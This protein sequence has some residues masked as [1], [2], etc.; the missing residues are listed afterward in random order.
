M[1]KYFEDY[2]L[3]NHQANTMVIESICQV[4]NKEDQLLDL[5]SHLLNAHLI[6]LNRISTVNQ[7]IPTPWQRL[8]KTEFSPFN[9][10]LLEQTL[11]YLH[12]ATLGGD[13][14]QTIAYQTSTGAKFS[15]TVQQIYFHILAHSAYHRGQIA[16]LLRNKGIDPPLSDY[17]FLKRGKS[18]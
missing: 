14:K 11:A 17:I 9:D 10:Q 2:F 6:W 4:S 15:N 18:Q 8:E 12:S 7:K 16:M 5:F 1:K 3:Y 13:L